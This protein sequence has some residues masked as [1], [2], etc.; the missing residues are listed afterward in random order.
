MEMTLFVVLQ[1]QIRVT[2]LV[3]DKLRIADTSIATL[4]GT[5]VEGVSPGR[6]EVQVCSYHREFSQTTL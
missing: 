3:N 2:D 1:A 4:S 5:V 6:T